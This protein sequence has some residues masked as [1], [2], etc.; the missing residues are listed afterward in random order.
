MANNAPF[1]LAGLF[2]SDDSPE[3]VT[4]DS[5]YQYESQELTFGDLKLNIVQSAF[6][7]TN[8]NKVWPGA[9]ILSEY[10]LANWER[11]Q[12]FKSMHF[13]ISFKHSFLLDCFHV[14]VR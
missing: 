3:E 5:L 10:L 9:Y 13:F 4:D 2:V 14:T 6:H 12:F 11:Y 7:P 8:A 1:S